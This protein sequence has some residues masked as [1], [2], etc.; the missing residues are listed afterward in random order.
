MGARARASSHACTACVWHAQVRAAMEGT[1]TR[2]L[3][4]SKR[5]DMLAAAEAARAE[6]RPYTVAFVGVN[7]VGKSTSLSKV[8]YYLKSNG[9]TPM[10]CACDTFRSGAVEQL[11]VHAQSLELP[12]YEKG[13]GKDAAGIATD[14]IRYAG[15]M[16]YDVVM[17]DTA[18]RMQ[19]GRQQQQQQQQ[20][21]AARSHATSVDGGPGPK[22]MYG[23]AEVPTYA[24]KPGAG[25]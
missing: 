18:G 23:P 7:G 16:G 21:G 4:P 17:V 15:Q 3:T 5:V 19:T 20:F 1:L 13:Y 9:F 11:R 8:A 6:G 10:L 25:C 12:L 24:M 14:G 22:E 2:I